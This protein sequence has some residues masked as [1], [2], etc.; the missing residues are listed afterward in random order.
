MVTEFKF[1]DVGE[2]ITEGMIKAWLVREGDTI[3]ED[4]TLAQVETDKAIV[5][6]PS[7]ADGT[8]LKILVPEGEKVKVGETMVTIGNDDEE[9][10]PRPSSAPSG[11]KEEVNEAPKERK[12]Q[13]APSGGKVF[14]LPRIRKLAKEKGIDLFYVKGTGPR[15]R[16]TEEDLLNY[17]KSNEEPSPG[18]PQKQKSIRVKLNY[19]F[20]GHIRYESYKGLREV[21]GN[22]LTESKFTAPHAAA[23]DE[24]D[25]TAL[26]DLRKGMNR[27]LAGKDEKLTFMPFIIKAVQ[28]SLMK[29]PT[30]NSTL[31]EEN[32]EIIIK[33]YYNIGVATDTEAG[34]MVPV[35]KRVE[36]KELVEI[37]KDMERLI[38]IAKDRTID[39]AELRGGTFTISNFGAIGGLFGVP[40]IN[41]P[42]AAIL[43]IGKIRELPRVVDGEIMVRKIM[44]ISVSFDHRIIDGAEVSRF[45]NTL[46]EY[47]ENPGMMFA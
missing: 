18:P 7:P 4:Q 23:M 30:L 29:H 40:I 31:D 26:W 25:M 11:D 27:E 28:K 37:Q 22:R 39:L 21:I 14:A 24:V 42:E 46:K 19:D 41:F 9:D 5:D 8:V 12:A 38:K 3:E 15:G 16:I 36:T 43:G 33:E 1:P 32:E 10:T 13:G 47:L 17:I 34:L 35:V 45:I 2:G 20:Y 44:G 6:M